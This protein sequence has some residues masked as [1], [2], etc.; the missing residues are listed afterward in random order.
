V[1]QTCHFIVT[2]LSLYCLGVEAFTHHQRIYRWGLKTWS[3]PSLRKFIVTLLQSDGVT[4][5][6]LGLAPSRAAV[7]LR[8]ESYGRFCA[9]Y[10]TLLGVFGEWKTCAP[11]PEAMTDHGWL[12][13]H[14]SVP[15]LGCYDN[16]DLGSRGCYDNHH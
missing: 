13:S 5:G 3:C 9:I 16:P 14:K 8:I 15:G 4:V 7:S 12:A 6:V 10:C 1:S 11:S 2:L